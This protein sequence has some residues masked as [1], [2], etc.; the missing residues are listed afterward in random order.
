MG[1]ATWYMLEVRGSVLKSF[2]YQVNDRLAN[3]SMNETLAHSWLFCGLPLLFAGLVCW[4]HRWVATRKPWLRMG[5]YALM[6]YALLGTYQTL[7]TRLTSQAQTQPINEET[8][9][10]LSEPTI[11]NQGKV[12]FD[13]RCVSCHGAKGEGAIGPNLTDPYWMYGG[14]IQDIFRTIRHGIPDTP[15]IAWKHSLTDE[16]LQAVANYVY[17]LLGTNPP[18]SKPP[19]GF[20]Y[21]RPSTA[22]QP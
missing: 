6:G 22:K 9:K 7:L 8:V 4:L 14:S 2:S 13:T 11:L 17:S 3:A 21:L 10:V 1:A 12:I 5:L 15:M 18:N 16:Q 19:Q 20:S